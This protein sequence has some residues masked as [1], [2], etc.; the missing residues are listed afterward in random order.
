LPHDVYHL[1][2]QAGNI[3]WFDRQAVTVEDKIMV[4][5]LLAKSFLIAKLSIV[6]LQVSGSDYLP[7]HWRLVID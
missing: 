2:K 5:K 1:I 4:R 3:H 7:S 6:L